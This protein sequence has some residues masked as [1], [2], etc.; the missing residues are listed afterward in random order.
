MRTYE[1]SNL[2]QIKYFKVLIQEMNLKMDIGFLIAASKIFA[3]DQWFN[4]SQESADFEIDLKK[5]QRNL[6]EVAGLSIASNNYNFYDYFHVSPIKIHLSL[7]VQGDRGALALH[8]NVLNVFLQSI[9]MV[10]T[11]VQDVVFR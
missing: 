1:H 10:L 8:A 6:K 9:G 5:M 7:S 11:D 2:V 4:R 3:A